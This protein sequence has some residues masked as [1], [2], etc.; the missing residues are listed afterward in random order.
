MTQWR[1]RLIEVIRNSPRSDDILLE[2]IDRVVQLRAQRV[3]MAKEIERIDTEIAS[4]LCELRRRTHPQSVSK[5]QPHFKDL[6]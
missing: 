3:E 5:S 4:L 6:S 2:A 1:T